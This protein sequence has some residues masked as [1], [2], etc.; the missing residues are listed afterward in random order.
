MQIEFPRPLRT[1]MRR[2]LIDAGKREIGGILMA[3]E[4]GDGHFRLADFSVDLASGNRARFCRRP[5]HHDEA[6]DAFFATTGADYARFN[7]LG[8]WHSHPSFPAIP[9][10]QDA[11][12]MAGLVEAESSIPFSVLL[13]ART[14]WRYRL[15]MTAQ[16]FQ[17]GGFRSE[18]EIV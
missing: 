9:S 14:R 16:L 15:D 2:L 7:Y 1:R 18:V 5:E 6:L 10:A 12:S 4:V 3:E 11:A 13:I 17:R 8:E